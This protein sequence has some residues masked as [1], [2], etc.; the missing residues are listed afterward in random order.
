MSK[1]INTRLY[2]DMPD[3]GCIMGGCSLSGSNNWLLEDVKD[4]LKILVSE[5]KPYLLLVRKETLDRRTKL[6]SPIAPKILS[7]VMDGDAFVHIYLNT[8]KIPRQVIISKF[9]EIQ[10]HGFNDASEFAFE[11][12]VSIRKKD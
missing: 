5:I 7:A 2:K 1:R 9:V 12:C 10:I 11:A 4:Q 3:T 8:I 6:V